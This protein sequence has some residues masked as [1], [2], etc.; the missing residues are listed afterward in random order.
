MKSLIALLILI[1]TP[2]WAGSTAEQVIPG[3]ISVTAPF[4]SQYSSTNQLPISVYDAG[5]HPNYCYTSNGSGSP[6]TFQVCGSGGG[7]ID[8][9]TTA[10]NGG[11]NTYNLY[12]NAGVVGER[13]TTPVANGGTGVATAPDALNSLLASTATALPNFR[14]CVSGVRHNVA[15]CRIVVLGNSLEL[16]VQSSGALTTPNWPSDFAYALTAAGIP[17]TDNSFMGWSVP[18][19][20]TGS[21]LNFDTRM[22]AGSWTAS[23][24]QTL[25]GSVLDVSSGAT[26]FTF[27]PTNPV[28][29]FN[30]FYNSYGSAAVS[31]LQ[32][33]SGSTV[34]TSG[35]PTK[36]MQTATVTADSLGSKTLSMTYTSGGSTFVEGIEAYNS[37]VKSIQ[38]INAGYFGTGTATWDNSSD[39]VTSY[40]PVLT[41]LAPALT[42]IPCCALEADS[43][44]SVSDTQTHLQSAISVAQRSGSGDVVILV[45]TPNNVAD[46]TAFVA[47]E[48]SVAASYNPPIPIIDNFKRWVSYSIGNALGLYVDSIHLS[49]KGADDV[50]ASAVATLLPVVGGEYN[51]TNLQTGSIPFQIASGWLGQNNANLFWDNTN[52]RLGI[53]TTVPGAVE[54][55]ASGGLDIRGV[56]TDTANGLHLWFTGNTGTIR[57]SQNGVA[58]RQCNIDGAP[59]VLN[60]SSGG[61]IQ[62]GTGSQLS[63]GTSST[64]SR[65]NVFGG[66]SI[67]T[68]Y[69]AIAAPTNSAIIQGSVGIG[70]SANAANTVLDVRGLA[71]INGSVSNGTKFTM[72]GCSATTPIGGA[73]AGTYTSGTLGTCQVVI[74]MNG[75]T[76]LTA[77]TGWTCI[78]NDQ[79]T[80][81]DKQTTIDST[82][83][84]ATLSGTTASGDVV[85]FACFGY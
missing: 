12:D 41:Y 52:L 56:S 80:P 62:T 69:V 64:G 26:P 15:N 4:F 59:I 73:T 65:L 72:T 68:S 60:G 79:T 17:A 27:L 38:V 70:T 28:D 78:A 42:I 83:T 36:A 1:S 39:P 32:A 40:L 76:G 34:T 37:A 61:V 20:V 10:I 67:G 21:R 45:N 5:N 30:V 77:P 54:D 85:S 13:Q 48:H 50:A 6:A 19:N 35:S 23:N 55:I 22:S 51:L 66:V 81:A 7:A 49:K 44:L 11:T 58:W 9:G 31:T 33:G 46:P 82:T 14:A 24:F 29:T 16:G 71:A 53:G 63:V 47:M 8:I 57:C 43:G 25:G 3:T 18:G 2:V 84:T 74:K 75:A